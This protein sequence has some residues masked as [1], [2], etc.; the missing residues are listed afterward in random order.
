MNGD[1]EEEDPRFGTRWSSR[2]GE[3][4]NSVDTTVSSALHPSSEVLLWIS[5]RDGSCTG[6]GATMIGDRSVESR[7]LKRPKCELI[8]R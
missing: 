5:L 2:T 8:T 4:S 7:E 3:C 1:E 6:G